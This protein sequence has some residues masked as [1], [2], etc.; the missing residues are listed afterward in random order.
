MPALLTLWD[1]TGTADLVIYE[2][3]NIGAAI[4]ATRVGAPSVALQVALAAPSVFFDALLKVVDFP[5][6]AMIDPRPDTWRA[7]GSGPSKRIPIRSVGWSDPRA[8]MPDVLQRPALAPR[9]A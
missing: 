3:G 8:V 6:D 1:R 9:H 5:L 7:D 2:A 4:A